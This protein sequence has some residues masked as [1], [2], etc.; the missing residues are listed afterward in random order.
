MF[1]ELHQKLKDDCDLYFVLEMSLAVA[2]KL[3]LNK[4]REEEEN[5]NG[6]TTKPALEKK[7]Y[8]WKIYYLL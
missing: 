7:V 8:C 3:A 2:S 1:I 5:K 4:K 6:I